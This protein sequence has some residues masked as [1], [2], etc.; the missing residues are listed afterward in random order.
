VTKGT[1]LPAALDELGLSPHNAIAAGDAENDLALLQAAE[2]GAAV[3]NAV[4][5]PTAHADPYLGSPN[6]SGMTELLAGPLLD[7]QQ[8]LCPRRR[9]VQV[10]TFDD[11]Q[12]VLVPGC[13]GSLQDVGAAHGRSGDLRL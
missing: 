11:G 2:V 8:R 13:Q 7:G 5:S 9:R 12:P 4:P 10:G 3:A 6:G 1:G